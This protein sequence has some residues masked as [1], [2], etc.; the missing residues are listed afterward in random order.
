MPLQP[1]TAKFNWSLGEIPLANVENSD[2]FKIGGKLKAAP[3][4]SDFCKNL[5]LEFIGLL[6]VCLNLMLTF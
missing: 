2:A 3:A 6:R 1:M 4:N 5:L